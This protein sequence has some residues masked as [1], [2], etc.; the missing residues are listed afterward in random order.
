MAWAEI[1]FDPVPPAD[2]PSEKRI[3]T[4]DKAAEWLRELANDIEQGRVNMFKL[5]M[6]AFQRVQGTIN[7]A[8]PDDY[9]LVD[10]VRRDEPIKKRQ[11]E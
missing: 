7:I 5:N 8:L 10:K 11:G 2:T 3:P 4:E 9:L 1:K 6:D